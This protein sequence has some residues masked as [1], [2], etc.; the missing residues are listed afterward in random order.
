MYILQQVKSPVARQI[1]LVINPMGICASWDESYL[2]QQRDEQS[3]VM[4]ISSSSSSL[5]VSVSQ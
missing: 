5:P 2:Q 1:W 3:S 4:F